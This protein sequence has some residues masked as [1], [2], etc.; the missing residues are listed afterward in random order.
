MYVGLAYVRIDDLMTHVSESVQANGV[1]NNPHEFRCWRES[2]RVSYFCFLCVYIFVCT[3]S[4][5]LNKIIRPESS[6]LFLLEILCVVCLCWWRVFV[7]WRATLISLCLYTHDMVLC[8]CRTYSTVVLLYITCLSVISLPSDKNIVKITRKIISV[9]DVTLSVT[10]IPG[11]KH[12]PQDSN[13]KLKKMLPIIL[14]APRITL[15]C[16][17]V[18]LKISLALALH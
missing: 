18:F 12:D 1:P 7:T 13:L 10:L 14:K 17:V 11:C 5:K 3:W 4:D 16:L 6:L 15:A 9:T 2:V 8:T